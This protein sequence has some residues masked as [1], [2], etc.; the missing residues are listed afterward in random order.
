MTLELSGNQRQELDLDKKEKHP[1][2]WFQAQA[3]E[4]HF[5]VNRLGRICKL[6]TPSKVVAGLFDVL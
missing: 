5:V 4:I 2:M 3:S 1:L 6:P